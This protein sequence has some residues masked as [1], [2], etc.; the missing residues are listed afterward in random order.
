MKILPFCRSAVLPLVAGVT[1]MPA[2]ALA[3][4]EAEPVRV[5]ET[6][7][8]LRVPGR[9]FLQMTREARETGEGEQFVRTMTEM[10]GGR[11]LRRYNTLLPGMVL[12]DV[13]VG[14]ERMIEQVARLS[15][16]IESVAWDT[17]GDT[18]SPPNDPR[19]V[20]G[21]Q[22]WRSRVCIDPVWNAGMTGAPDVIVA[23]ID[24]GVNYLA[25]DLAPNM[26]V[27]QLEATGTADV[28]DDGNGIADDVYGV[29]YQ[30][31]YPN[32]P[33]ACLPFCSS[34]SMACAGN[35]CEY[36]SVFNS[37]LGVS[38]D[39]FDTDAAEW[40]GGA[41]A[42]PQKS[43]AWTSRAHGT[44]SAATIGAVGNNSLEAT[45]VVWDT[46]IMGVRVND[47]THR[48]FFASDFISGMEY[49]VIMGARVASVTLTYGYSTAMEDAVKAATD[50]GLVIVASAGNNG[51]DL[52]NSTAQPGRYPA[53]FQIA[54]VISVGA[55][56]CLDQR[57]VPNPPFSGT[58]S[59]WGATLVDIFAP[60]VGIPTLDTGY[61]GTSA[62]APLVAG[63]VALYLQHNPTASPS[64]VEQAI[65]G[66]ARYVPALAD[67]CVA[68]GIVNVQNLMN[69]QGA[70]PAATPCPY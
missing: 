59:S 15:R 52:D 13:P 23:V 61:E 39:P 25:P 42:C 2:V 28:D 1:L 46:Q 19:A 29:G 7:E 43:G 53:A 48:I 55:S 57:A 44:L 8:H 60:G 12:L 38:E 69:V 51:V 9:I 18:N 64:E 31:L 66:T 14:H 20:N 70:C 45:G 63:V 26:W 68:Q 67:K 24:T 5:L 11:V 50:Q 16:E 58:D 4:R 33:P 65:V 54:G 49:A 36:V 47:F 10:F 56:N 17:W 3:Q 27:N 35:P 30:W 22:W 6:P 40:N 32:D 21:D 34:S 37:D 41:C 62:A